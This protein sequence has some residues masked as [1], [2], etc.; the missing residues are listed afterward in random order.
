MPTLRTVVTVA[1]EALVEIPAVDSAEAAVT[2]VVD[3]QAGHHPADLAGLREDSAVLVAVDL[4][5]DLAGD[6]RAE[7]VR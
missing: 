2:L 6:L 3:L 7:V 1:A 5:V 4:A